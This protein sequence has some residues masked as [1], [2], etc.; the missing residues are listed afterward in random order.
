MRNRPRTLNGALGEHIRF[1]LELSIFVQH[2]K[3]TEQIIGGVIRKSQPVCPVVNQPELGAERIVQSV[4][5]PLF[6][7]NRFVAGFLKLRIHQPID[8]IPQSHH[9]LNA[10]LCRSIQFRAHHHRVFAEIY[11][12]VYEGIAVILHVRV[13]GNRFGNLLALRQFHD[14]RR[15]VFAAD[16]LN[17]L[18]QLLLQV[19]PRN[20]SA[21]RF[22]LVAIH[23]LIPCHAAQHHIGMADEVAVDGDA[24]LRLPQMHPIRLYV[25]GTFP[26]LQKEDVRRHARSRI[27]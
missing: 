15:A 16:L 23:A 11:L 5:L 2:L 25:D 20:G 4:Q 9:A 8:R 24:V 21:R 10:L 26:F 27:G 19:R 13:G 7:F 6:A 22:L 17:R 1:S 3:R 12:A 18:R 14:L